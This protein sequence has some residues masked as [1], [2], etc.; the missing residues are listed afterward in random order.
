MTAGPGVG[1]AHPRREKPPWTA[2]NEL[3]HQAM[4]RWVNEK[5][6]QGGGLR[7]LPPE[8]A[9]RLTPESL[10]ESSKEYLRWWREG[11]PE[12]ELAQHGNIKPARERVRKVFPHLADLLQ[13]PKLKRGEKYRP[14]TVDGAIGGVIHRPGVPFAKLVEEHEHKKS[15]AAAVADV[16][17]IKRIW[18]A[19]E[20]HGYGRTNRSKGQVSAIEI[21]AARNGVSV[22]EVTERL[23]RTK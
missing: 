23:K 20:P 2:L 4:I 5:L 11:G 19:P 13:L 15:V 8:H 16:T 6:D 18:A 3:D 12:L 17:R 1:S 7:G 21:A 22:A 9:A 14:Y 10:A